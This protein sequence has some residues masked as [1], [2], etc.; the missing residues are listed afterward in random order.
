MENLTEILLI[1]IRQ[2]RN[3]I[4]NSLHIS[5]L[6]VSEILVFLKAPGSE[7]ARKVLLVIAF[8]KLQFSGILFKN[9]AVSL[10]F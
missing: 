5:P 2:N 8:F 7:K 9:S 10:H 1:K 6:T 4:S 3:C